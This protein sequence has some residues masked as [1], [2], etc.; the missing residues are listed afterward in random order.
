MLL[1]LF[2]YQIETT[3]VNL[4]FVFVFLEREID[5]MSR[6]G[7]EG[8]R[9]RILSRLHARCRAQYGAPTQDHEIMT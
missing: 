3:F 6:E 1:P 2:I 4:I 8:E 5:S 7:A 9:E